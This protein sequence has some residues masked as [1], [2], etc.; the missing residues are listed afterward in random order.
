MNLEI[1]QSSLDKLH[2]ILTKRLH[3]GCSRGSQVLRDNT[4]IDTKRLWTTTRAELPTTI[5]HLI[6]ECRIVAGGQEIYGVNRE[7]DIKREVNYAIFVESRTN[8][9][10]ESLNDIKQVIIDSLTSN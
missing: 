8:Y 7:Q 5:Q 3:R 6:S 1:N 9:A 4:P 10:R 2:D